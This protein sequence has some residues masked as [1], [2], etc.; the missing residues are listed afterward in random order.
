MKSSRVSN[1]PNIADSVMHN[2]QP[3][4]HPGYVGGWQSRYVLTKNK[5]RS[6]PAFE[7]VCD[8]AECKAKCDTSCEKMLSY[9]YIVYVCGSAYNGLVVAIFVVVSRMRRNV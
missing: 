2:F 1:K 8:A 4:A 3:K 7:N 9:V 6:P 5:A